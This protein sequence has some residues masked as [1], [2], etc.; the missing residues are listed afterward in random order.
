MERRLKIVPK[1][2]ILGQKSTIDEFRTI[3]NTTLALCEPLSYDDYLIQSADFVSPPK[4]H[5]AHTTWFFEQFVLLPYVSTYRTFHPDYCGLFNSYYHSVS[6]QIPR[7]RRG[8]LSRPTLEEVRKY[9]T[10]VDSVVFELLSMPDIPQ[11]LLDLILL[12]LQHEQQHQELLL[13]DICHIFYSNPMKPV[14]SEMNQPVGYRPQRISYLEFPEEI[15]PIGAEHIRFS[16]DNE[17]PKHLVLVP[18]FQLADRLVTCGE[19][20]EFIEAKGY[21]NPR[22]WLSDGWDTVRRSGWKAPLYWEWQG[23]HWSVFGLTGFRPWNVDEP[24]CHVS[25]FEADAYARFRGKRLPTEFA[26]ERVAQ[27]LGGP[28]GNLLEDRAL[29]PLPAETSDQ[30]K[31]MFG[32]VWNWTQSAYSPYPGYEIPPDRLGEYNGKFMCNQFVLRGGSFATPRSHIRPTYRN[33][34][35]PDMRWQFAGIRLEGKPA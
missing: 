5:L 10:R 8:T 20:L 29:R 13:M 14:Y 19:Y 25:Y 33:F 9:R 35:A 26:W 23:T 12:G 34:Y 11:D 30:M 1:G 4:W 31:Q 21:E 7:A 2:Q 16:F 6:P 3:R 27:E 24:V 17:R 28:R 22:W 15:V 32:D 18:A